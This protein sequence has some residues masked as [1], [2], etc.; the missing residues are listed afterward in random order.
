MAQ[1]GEYTE[2]KF[3]NQRPVRV[4]PTLRHLAHL[5]RLFPY[6]WTYRWLIAVGISGLLLVRLCDALMPL[7]LK[8]VVDS[9]AVGQPV[10]VGPVIGIFG[11][12]AVRALISIFA[13]RMLRRVAIDTSYD[14]RKRF[15]GHVQKMGPM[16]FNQF[17]TGD[18]MSRSSGDIAMVRQVV[19]FGW[20]QVMT[21]AFSMI[22]GV[23]FMLYLAPMLTLLVLLP[24]PLV[25]LVGIV[26]SKRLFPLIREQRMAMDDVTSFTSENLN[27]IRTVQAMAQE[28]REINRFD[29]LSTRYA[30]LVYRSNRY[31]ARMNLIMPFTSVASTLIIIGYGGQLVL[32][33]ELSIGTFTAFFAYM[34]MVTGPIRQLGGWL[35]SIT[36]AAAATER[37][38]EVLDYPIEVGDV[39]ETEGSLLEGSLLADGSLSAEGSL[40]ADGSS[41]TDGSKGISRMLG[42]IELRNFSYRYPDARAAA[43]DDIN[44]TIGAGEIV[45]IL[46]R[47]GSGKST[48]LRSLARLSEPAPGTVFIDGRDIRDYP[49]RTVRDNIGLVPQDPF[50]FSLTVRDNLTYDDPS[51]PDDAVADAAAQAELLEAIGRFPDGMDTVVG[52]RG[53]TLS[54]GQKQRATLARS[55]IRDAPILAMDDCFSSIDTRTEERILRRLTALRAGRTTLL[56]SHRVSTARHADRIFVLDNGRVAESGTHA[57]LMAQ[58]G[59][60]ANL[61]A[62]QSNQEQAVARKAALLRDLELSEEAAR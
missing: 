52:E 42:R 57:E 46:G 55:L 22:V 61:D 26:M 13:N 27:G 32:D 45:A 2:R 19:A 48:L 10:I 23:S 24:T 18:V 50:L 7:F 51:R 36:S 12:T 38:F 16:F 35:V 44:I 9:L 15:F 6:A 37:L 33:G 20:V 1:F 58:G 21:F 30:S 34:I 56:V 41:P 39:R 5:R 28:Q 29:E 40:S 11:V 47:V 4:R 43:I 31:R 25:A 59:Y 3:R 54:G 8:T 62:V 60:Y 17:G 53:I 49:L 14:L